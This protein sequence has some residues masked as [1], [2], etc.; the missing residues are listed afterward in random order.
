VLKGIRN[1]MRRD[2][3]LNNGFYGVQVADDEAESE[4]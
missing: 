3:L 2:G 1:Q 4:G